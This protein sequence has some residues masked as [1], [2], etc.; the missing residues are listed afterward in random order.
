MNVKKIYYENVN[1]Y[2]LFLFII[3]LI[4][5]SW[6]FYFGYVENLEVYF[7]STIFLTVMLISLVKGITQGLVTSLITIFLYSTYLM[8]RQFLLPG[9]KE[10]TI[11]EIFWIP[12]IPIGAFIGGRI[13]EFYKNL[14]NRLKEIEYSIDELVT[15][16]EETGLE[17]RKNFIFTVEEEIKRGKRYGEKFAIML[18]KINFL[19]EFRDQYG[20]SARKRLIKMIADKLNTIFRL[21]DK[22]ARLSE[23]EFGTIL[24]GVTE[25]TLSIVK[26][27]I[28]ESLSFM[29]VK[30]GEENFKR[31]R[32]YVNVGWALFPEDGEEFPI[33]YAKAKHN[34]EFD[35]D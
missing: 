35:V 17:N 1:L 32:L 28:K 5:N 24:I 7:I 6:F 23:D 11:E 27:R 26:N 14:Y 10:I 3:L 21:E 2:F 16:D 20:E 25:D 30:I 13:S 33:L 9:R 12:I 34:Y 15:R 8:V 29:D 31:V 19:K 4:I 22:K 18:I